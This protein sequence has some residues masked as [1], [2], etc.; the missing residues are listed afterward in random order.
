MFFGDGSDGDLTVTQSG[1]DAARDMYHENLALSSSNGTLPV[2]RTNG[3][4]IHVRNRILFVTSGSIRNNGTDGGIATPGIGGAMATVGSGATGGS[5]TINTGLVGLGTAASLGGSGG[6]GGSGSSPGGLGGFAGPLSAS[7]GNMNHFFPAS[8]GFGFGVNGPQMIFG[9]GG[10]GGGGGPGAIQRG[11]GGGGGGG[12][13]IVVAR[14]IYS[15]SGSLG[16]LQANGGA[17]GAGELGS[18]TGGGGGGGGG[19]LAVITSFY[20]GSVRF[21]ANPGQGGSPSGGGSA[22]SAGSS[23]SVLLF[24]I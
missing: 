4:R 9:G 23:G 15:V 10:G 21:E 20:T 8:V 2:Y 14:E 17:G 7:A 1:Y 16:L 3:Y 24:L 11:G 18:V 5:G 13:T 19:T 22:G 12:V 6:V